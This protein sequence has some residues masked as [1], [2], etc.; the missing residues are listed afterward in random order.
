M[1]V[2]A[3][4]LV[5][6]DD[7]AALAAVLLLAD[8]SGLRG[9]IVTGASYEARRAWVDA[10]ALAWAGQGPVVRIPVAVTD[11]RL[12]GG[13]DLAATLAAGRPV[14][15]RG[16]LAAADGGLCVLQMAERAAPH[17]SGA[18][19]AALDDGLVRVQRD[20]LDLRQSARFVLIAVDEHEDDEPPVAP[21]LAARVAFLVHVPDAWGHGAP[22]LPA[23][24]ALRELRDAV[25]AVRLDDEQERALVEAADGFGVV[26]VRAV[27][28]ARRAACAS[29]ALESRT[30]VTM[31]DLARAVR[32]VLVP[33][34]TR[35]P[36]P[37]PDASAPDAPP[38][39]PPPDAD[40]AETPPPDEPTA[41][42]EPLADRIVEAALT[43]LPPDLLA[44]LTA[45]RERRTAAAAGRSGA[46]AKAKARGR[47]V[48]VDR[49][50]PRG[51]R[52]LD[53]LATLRTAAPWQR[54]RRDDSPGA[55]GRIRVRG[56][57]LRIRRLRQRIGTTVIFLVDASGSQALQRLGEA[58]GAVELLL[59][60]SYVRRDRV[61]LIAFRG[62]AAEL[63]LAPTRSLARARRALAGLPGGGGTPLASA[64][65]AGRALALRVRR[66]GGKPLLVL[67][68]D[69]RANVARDGTGGRP[70]AEADARQSATLLGADGMPALVVDASPR[71]N[72][73]LADLARLMGARYAPLPVVRADVLQAAVR[74]VAAE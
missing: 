59:A 66:E 64:L 36:A 12:L 15:E 68:T 30:H 56:D 44:Q 71:P 54:L 55:S 7:A 17:V 14:A 57:D 61:A 33:R 46:L 37:P 38:P 28:F 34:A 1:T 21:A 51:G 13:L 67:L 3:P 40:S 8:P 18:L 2:L 26:D 27:L 70:Q 42:E 5:E 48:G 50:L 58:K 20:G 22:S 23:G 65:D 35:M 69:G 31:D 4:P 16:L 62:R 11:D 19:A 63:L 32:L 6:R 24:D 52:R 10:L 9:A 39:P 60:E 74:A 73:A 41:S 29:A 47:Q 49:G 72:P 43:N 53:L 25:A 45:G